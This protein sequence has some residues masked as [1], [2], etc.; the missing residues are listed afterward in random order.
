MPLGKGHR[1]SVEQ[2]GTPSTMPRMLC[3]KLVEIGTVVLEKRS[4]YEK[5]T[6][7]LTDK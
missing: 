1:L 5:F 6:D 3:T 2:T 4:K 7:R